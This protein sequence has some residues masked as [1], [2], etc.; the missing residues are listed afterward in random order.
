MANSSLIA[1]RNLVWTADLVEGSSAGDWQADAPLANLATPQLG[2]VGRFV[3]NSLGGI[4]TFDVEFDADQTISLVGM[5]NAIFFGADSVQIA[6]LDALGDPII[7]ITDL[8]VVSYSGKEDY[9]PVNFWHLFD[10]P[11]TGVRKIV[12]TIQGDEALTPHHTIGGLWLSPIWPLTGLNPQYTLAVVDPSQVIT[13]DANQTRATR[14][15][16]FRRL[17]ISIADLDRRTGLGIADTGGDEFKVSNENS[18][19]DL[20]LY[21]GN[22]SPVVVMPITA[23]PQDIHTLGIYGYLQGENALQGNTTSGDQTKKKHSTQLTVRESL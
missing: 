9:V 21:S 10:T 4:C 2:E 11:Q 20:L 22:S 23:T 3:A 6:L 17:S 14:M 19:L 1:Y 18:L 7:N 8:E 12:I 16:R 13:T 15:R 5:L